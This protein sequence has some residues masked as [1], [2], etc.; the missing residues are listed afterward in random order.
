MKDQEEKRKKKNNCF[1]W[2]TAD[3]S[4]EAD[5]SVT[6]CQRGRKGWRGILTPT[7]VEFQYVSP[8][9]CT[10]T[11]GPPSISHTRP[12]ASDSGPCEPSRTVERALIN[13]HTHLSSGTHRLYGSPKRSQLD[14]LESLASH[15]TS[16]GE[17]SEFARDTSPARSCSTSDSLLAASQRVPATDIEK[18]RNSGSS[19]HG[20]GV[21]D[22]QTDRQTDGRSVER[23]KKLSTYFGCDERET[24]NKRHGRSRVA[25]LERTNEE[26]RQRVER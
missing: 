4:P 10:S 23:G 21:R 7:D 12:W 5:T 26:Q 24:N 13:W 17:Q 16:H 18:N 6:H 20:L 14:F 3:S 19:C 22:R 2:R 8:E 9:L 25:R 15:V 1:I 11:C